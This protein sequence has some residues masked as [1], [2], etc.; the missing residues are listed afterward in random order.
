MGKVMDYIHCHIK[1]Y[2]IFFSGN[3]IDQESI[4]CEKTEEIKF[5]YK[6]RNEK[7]ASFR[8]Y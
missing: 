7:S 2:S 5:E 3:L 8:G 4:T 6:D 1:S